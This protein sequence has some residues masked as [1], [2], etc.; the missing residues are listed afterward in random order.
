MPIL[1]IENIRKCYDLE[2]VFNNFSLRVD[3]REFVVLLGPSGCG[4][5]TLL[6]IIAGTE[7]PEEGDVCI[8]GESVLGKEA[9]D[10]PVALVPQK[11]GTLAHLSARE[12]ISIGAIKNPLFTESL[13]GNALYK[14]FQLRKTMNWNGPPPPILQEIVLDAARDCHALEF[15]DKL[16]GILSGG[17]LRR[18]VLA[19]AI[20]QGA[21][22]MLFDE[23]FDSLDVA[24]RGELRELVLDVHKKHGRT[25]I[26]VTHDVADA[27]RMADRVVVLSSSGSILQEGTY[28][29]IYSSPR[30]DQVAQLIGH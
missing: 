23:P 26:L 22:I 6:R 19:R 29:E 20:A 3:E 24:L 11:F 2:D 5:S 12:N 13:Q 10:R 27:K 28:D 15:L 21:P 7:F 18:T 16:S 1:K 9:Y 8:Q 17:Q 14:W 30:N 4:K 25:S